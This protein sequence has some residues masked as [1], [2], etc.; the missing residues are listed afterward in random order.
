M[1][2]LSKSQKQVQKAARDFAKGEFQ[3]DMAHGFEKA[4]AYPVDVWKKAA[5]L[6]FI[7]IHVDE[8]FSG[9]GL[10]VVEACVVAEEFCR[11]D[12]S[13]G[14]AI[15]LASYTSECILHFG[16]ENL[17]KSYLPRIVE[18]KI[19][20]TGA[21]TESIY[22]MD[23]TS[24]QATAVKNNGK[25]ILNGEKKYVIHGPGA[26]CCIVLCRTETN[27]QAKHGGLTMFLVEP[28]TQGVQFNH[29]GDQLSL[30]MV[31][32][33]TMIMNQVAVDETNCI[34]R[35]GD[36]FQQLSQFLIQQR[37]I[38]AAQAVGIAQGAY[39]RAFQYVKE[40][41][42]FGKKLIQF[43]ITRHKLAEMATQVHMARLMSYHAAQQWDQGIK[44]ISVSA[45]AKMVSTQCAVHVSDE[46]V[47]L[48]GGYGYMC[49]Y[50]VERF[51]RDAKRLQ[52]L[53]GTRQMHLDIISEAI[54]GK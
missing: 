32:I 50:D 23:Y 4:C 5:D 18:G 39:D 21:F 37:I 43:Q 30:N 26:G 42:Q 51:L 29:L 13:L 54:I 38:T 15:G 53:Y 45:M 2:E 17:K 34:G 28:N 22:G 24:T 40:R 8:A 44:D 14:I 12:S 31:P 1:F 9:G 47:Q 35:V 10:G 41:E 20:S 52:T 49:E 36:G 19:R 16:N 25:W 27:P 6:G 7:G 48:L 11:Q 3:K 46:A 33:Y